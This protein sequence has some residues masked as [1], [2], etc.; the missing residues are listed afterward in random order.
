MGFTA[1]GSWVK[2]WA[3]KVNEEDFGTGCRFLTCLDWYGEVPNGMLAA[4]SGIKL[5]ASND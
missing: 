3:I 1:L 4:T 2:G 5:Q